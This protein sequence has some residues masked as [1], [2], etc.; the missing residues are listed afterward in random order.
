MKKILLPILSLTLAACSSSQVTV[1]RYAQMTVTSSPPTATP[2]PTPTL[3]PQFIALQAQI[4]AAGERFTLAPDGTIQD[5]AKTVPGLSVDKNGAITLRGDSSQVTLDAADVSFDDTKGVSV[6]GYILDEATGLWE[7]LPVFTIDQLRLMT[8]DQI[9]EAAPDMPGYEKQDLGFYVHYI[10]ASGELGASYN[11]ETGEKLA[12]PENLQTLEKLPTKIENAESYPEV[13]V[14]DLP[15]FVAWLHYKY[16]EK[17]K[18]LKPYPF[19]PRDT[20][21]SEFKR[22]GYAASFEKVENVDRY[23]LFLGMIKI[24]DGKTPIFWGNPRILQTTQGTTRVLLASDGW[25]E[26]LNESMTANKYFTFLAQNPTAKN[27]YQIAEFD[28]GDIE[29]ICKKYNESFL[30]FINRQGG[31]TL[32]L[33]RYYRGV[34]RGV[35][36]VIDTGIYPEELEIL[37]IFMGEDRVTF[38]IGG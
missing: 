6:K 9:I 7:K 32:Y 4:A 28:G 2:I 5:G 13:E 8:P 11:F 30:G 10:N 14:T 15:A 26:K 16:D 21:S 35:S 19:V 17:A 25:D 33:K 27:T 20:D 29:T 3:H 38:T 34:Q 1:T 18:N 23:T 31:C 24:M 36:N 22:H 12:M 37:P